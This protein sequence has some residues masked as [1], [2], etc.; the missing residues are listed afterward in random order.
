MVE[1]MT[2]NNFMLTAK[3]MEL[4]GNLQPYTHHSWM[5]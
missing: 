3:H 2:Q 5:V 4:E 1:N